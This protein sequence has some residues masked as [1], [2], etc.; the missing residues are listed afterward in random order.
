MAKIK[1]VAGIA[2]KENLQVSVPLSWLNGVAEALNKV[3]IYLEK[4]EGNDE[5]EYISMKEATKRYKTT[6]KTMHSLIDRGMLE[7][8]VV[9]RSKKIK[10]YKGNRSLFKARK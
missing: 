8:V 6:Y 2:E 5:Y 3:T 10:L 1:E 7:Y 4:I 9:G